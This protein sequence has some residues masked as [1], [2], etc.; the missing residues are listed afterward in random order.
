[1]KAGLHAEWHEKF[2]IDLK[3][4]W[5]ETINFIVKDRCGCRADPIIGETGI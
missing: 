5:N 4:G 2:T 1:L 3:P